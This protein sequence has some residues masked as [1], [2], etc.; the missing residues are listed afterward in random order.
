[1]YTAMTP[2]LMV[3]SV[4]KAI[5]FYQEALGFSLVDSVPKIWQSGARGRAPQLLWG[6]VIN[7]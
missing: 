5:T 6:S 3:K 4:D 1:M 2:N 7:K